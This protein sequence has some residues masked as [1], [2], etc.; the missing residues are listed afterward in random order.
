MPVF[1]QIFKCQSFHKYSHN[2]TSKIMFHL[3][4]EGPLTKSGQHL[5]SSQQG[6]AIYGPG[7]KDATC[8]CKQNN[9]HWNKDTLISIVFYVLLF[10]PTSV[11][12]SPVV[13]TETLWP[14]WE[15]SLS[16]IFSFPTDTKRPEHWRFLW[17]TQEHTSLC[18]TGTHGAPTLEEHSYFSKGDGRGSHLFSF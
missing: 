11:E 6:L 9:L 15:V 1:P 18:P 10:L 16:W 17:Y 5:N 12:E 14:A 4:S 7:V 8:F 2:H 3:L 13:R